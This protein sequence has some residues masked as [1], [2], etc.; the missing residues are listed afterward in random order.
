MSP[1]ALVL[2]LCFVNLV[3]GVAIGVVV[4][5]TVLPAAEHGRGQGGRGRPDMGRMLEKKLDLDADQAKRVREIYAARRPAFEAVMRESQPRM[6]ALR[7]ESDAQ[8]RAILRPDQQVKFDEMRREWQQRH[9]ERERRERGEHAPVNSESTTIK[10]G[11][12]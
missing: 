5:R 3:A 8:I 2:L 12:R 10:E 7:Q 4:D 11:Q 9:G 1:R 6:E